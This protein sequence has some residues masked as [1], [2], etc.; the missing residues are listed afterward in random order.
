MFWQRWGNKSGE[1]TA[2]GCIGRCILWPLQ[3][4]RGG[5]DGLS[6]ILGVPNNWKK[7]KLLDPKVSLQARC[8]EARHE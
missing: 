2:F 4:H 1:V 6:G 5:S 8:K 7:S 3:E